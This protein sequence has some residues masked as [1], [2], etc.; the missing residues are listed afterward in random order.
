MVWQGAIAALLKYLA[1]KDL[2]NV[3]GYGAIHLVAVYLQGTSKAAGV[4]TIVKMYTKTIFGK[5]QTILMAE[6]ILYSSLST[7][8]CI[9]SSTGCILCQSS[10]V[11][12]HM[13]PLY[14]PWPSHD[15]FH[16]TR[17]IGTCLF[18]C[19]LST[20]CVI[21]HDVLMFKINKRYLEQLSV[22]IN[23]TANYWLL[24]VIFTLVV[25]QT[26]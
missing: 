11:A 18:F 25:K 5:N 22:M 20:R 3:P 21:H 14:P 13:P 2:W 17:C 7:K 12:V 15:I 26:F 19:F 8:I 9:I 6:H 24:C 16:V 23:D 4:F 1:A 10:H